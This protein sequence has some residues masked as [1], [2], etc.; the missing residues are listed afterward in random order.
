M[1]ETILIATD[2]SDAAHTAER[3][4]LLRGPGLAREQGLRQGECCQGHQGA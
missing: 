1:I 4:W 2:G 3:A